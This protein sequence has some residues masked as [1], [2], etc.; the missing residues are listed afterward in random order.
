MTAILVIDDEITWANF[1]RDIV[2]PSVSVL[3]ASSLEE[4]R[5]HFMRYRDTIAMIIIDGHVR[6]PLDDSIALVRFFREEKR[7][8]GPIVAAS[9]D[10]TNN[11]KLVNA[12][13]NHAWH[14]KFPD[15]KEAWKHHSDIFSLFSSRS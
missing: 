10:P 15:R 7:F 9:G 4:G 2:K 12:G 3:H 11:A 1:Y 14:S 6:A 8:I 13:C 5:T